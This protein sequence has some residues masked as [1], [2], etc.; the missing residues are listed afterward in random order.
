[1]SL[2]YLVESIITV[3]GSWCITIYSDANWVLVPPRNRIVSGL[4]YRL[5][6][7]QSREAHIKLWPRARTFTYPVE[8]SHPP[9]RCNFIT[10]RTCGGWIC[11]PIAGRS[12]QQKGGRPHAQGIALSCGGERCLF[13]VD[14]MTPAMMCGISTMP[15]CSTSRSSSGPRWG[16]TRKATT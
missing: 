2:F 9:A 1:M 8:S 10:T 14:F 5:Q 16:R 11:L 6:T 12:S 15:S 13:S 3:S 4:K 7:H